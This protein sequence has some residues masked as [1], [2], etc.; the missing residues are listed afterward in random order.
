[1]ITLLLSRV[2]NVAT[3]GIGQ[4]KCL[5]RG[6]SSQKLPVGPQGE[7]LLLQPCSCTRLTLRAT[8]GEQR[9]TETAVGERRTPPRHRT[10][11]H[12]ALLLNK[13]R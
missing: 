9:R 8:R 1:M 11:C 3:V 5:L 13:A 6:W 4:R 10:T 2:N 12:S 7:P